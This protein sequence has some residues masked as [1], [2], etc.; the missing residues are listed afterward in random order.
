MKRWRQLLICWWL[1]AKLR[2]LRVRLEAKVAD[3]ILSA[4]VLDYLE[5]AESEALMSDREGWTNSDQFIAYYEGQLKLVRWIL[6]GANAE[7][8]PFKRR[9]LAR[10][11][12][13]VSGDG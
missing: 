8:R 7:S 1:K 4:R 11:R 12:S 5:E 3:L 10:P 13:D 2:F 9:T 6:D